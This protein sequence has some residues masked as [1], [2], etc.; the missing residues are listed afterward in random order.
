MR[1]TFKS[2][3]KPRFVPGIALTLGSLLGLACTQIQT[4]PPTATPKAAA[5][6]PAASERSS[7]RLPET[8]SGPRTLTVLAV[9][10]VYRIAGI[11]DGRYGSM[12]RLRSLR[13]ELERDDPELLFL[14]AG[15]FL[16]PSLLSRWFLGEQMIDVMN[17]LDGDEQ[18]FDQR[19]FVTFGNHEFDKEKE[20]DIAMLDRRIEESQFS[21]LGTNIDFKSNDDGWPVIA[22]DHLVNS[23][24]VELSGI[25]VGLFSLSIDEKHP[26]Y[27]H[28]FGQPKAVARR[29]TADLRR[30]GAE[31]VIALTH[32][33]MT[34]DVDLLRKL[35]PDGPDL[36]F[37]GHEHNRQ[38]QEVDGRWIIK[39]DA[40]ARSATV[41]KVKL[42]PGGPPKVEFEFRQLGPQ[43]PV[44]PLVQARVDRWLTNHDEVYCHKI[45][46][47]SGCLEKALG[48]TQERLIGEELTMRRFETNLGNWV[49]DQ[50]LQHF[51]DLGAQAAFINSGSLRLNQDIPAN[52]DVT[53]RHIEE[54][55]QYPSELRLLRITGETLQQVVSHAVTDWTG[56]GKWL[57]V[58]GFAFRHDPAAAT[59]D[60]LTLL[61]ADGPR[62]VDPDEELLVVTSSFLADPKTGQDGYTMLT[63]DLQVPPEGDPVTLRDL[64]V[65]GL[66]AAGTEGIAPSVDGRICNAE[67]DGPCL[68]VER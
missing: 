46:E 24:I 7:A 41:A 11:E 53:R 19:L 15:D 10:D 21:W 4:E 52:T 68:A 39:A 22:A 8:S 26:D 3:V 42:Q 2:Q 37:G 51:A 1:N 61:T 20:D 58:A 50:A 63:E 35:G 25:R 6:A 31:L 34:D 44:D 28:A 36:A 29:L 9:N 30:R 45:G 32:L 40:D 33:K 27:V 57:Q 56:N 47:P 18:A 65:A 14:H 12:A 5:E 64:V 48:H 13:S 66:A 23:A 16:F 17:L 54:T 38:A 67:R 59:A 43:S 62:P 55:F 60:R 49:L